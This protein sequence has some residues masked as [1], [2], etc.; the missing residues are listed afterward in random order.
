MGVEDQDDE[1]KE[2]EAQGDEADGDED[3]EDDEILCQ[4][5][6]EAPIVIAKSPGC[7]TYEEIERH[8]VT[9][10]PYRSWCPVCV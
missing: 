7:P 6:G 1:S 8:N 5:C 9:H 4:P 10:L 3:L 2:Q